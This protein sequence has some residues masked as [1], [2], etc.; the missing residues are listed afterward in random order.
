MSTNPNRF[1]ELEQL[2]NGTISDRVIELRSVFKE[3]KL[4]VQPSWDEKTGWWAGVERLSDEQKK[5][6]EYF[7]TV[8]ET[9]DKARENTKIVIKNGHTFDLNLPVDKINWEWVKHNTFIAMSFHEAQMSQALFYVHIEGR[10]ALASLTL[11]EKR[12]EA[13]N[14]VLEDPQVNHVNRALLL[15][16]EMQND[17]PA[18]V[19]DFLLDT[20]DKEPDKIL[21]VYRDKSMRIYLLF[22]LAKQKSVITEDVNEGVFKYGVSI[23]GKTPELCIAYLQQNEDILMLLERDVNPQYFED[24]QAKRSPLEAAAEARKEKKEATEDTAK[25]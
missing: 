19:K 24:K 22:A 23:L 3:G 1:A 18:T 8:G 11:R 17:N 20:A 21:R 4:T 10:E 14:L 7:V 16:M 12:L 9:K 25:K 13:G 5:T 6:K 15:G 2:E